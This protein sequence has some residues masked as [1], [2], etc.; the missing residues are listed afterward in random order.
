MQPFSGVVNEDGNEISLNSEHP[1]KEKLRPSE[2]NCREVHHQRQKDKS[3]QTG[4]IWLQIPLQVSECS[5]NEVP[6]ALVSIS[7]Q[8]RQ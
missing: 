2:K 3:F 7:R 4:H 6:L 5:E 1:W 8:R